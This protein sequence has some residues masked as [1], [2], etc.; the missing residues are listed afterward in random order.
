MRFSLYFLESWY[1]GIGAAIG[2]N[3]RYWIGYA[4]KASTQA[5]PWPT[6]LINV[7]GSA[8]LGSFTAMALAKGWGTNS[9]LFFAVGVCGGFTTFSTFSY[10]VVATYYEKSE[11]LALIYALLSLVLSVGACW[12]GGHFTHR[13]LARPPYQE[14][15]FKP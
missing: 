7:L 3:A 5:F 11:K 14:N 6:L 8:L 2:A 1:V 10:E 13:A 9:R 12:L 15:P 4:C